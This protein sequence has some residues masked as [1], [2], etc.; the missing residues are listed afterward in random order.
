MMKKY[1]VL[2][3]IIAF[4]FMSLSV[5]A[6]IVHAASADLQASIARLKN[7]PDYRGKVLSTHIKQRGGRSVLEV[8]ILKK[9]DR[10]VIVYIDPQTGG[11]IGDS[12]R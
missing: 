11:V 1:A 2:F 8:R 5:H 3:G 10:I 4:V 9:N 6:P 12:I 7:N